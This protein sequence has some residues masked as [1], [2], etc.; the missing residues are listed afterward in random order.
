M[1]VTRTAAAPPESGQAVARYDIGP[2]LPEGALRLHLNEFR[3]PHAA[4]VLRAAAAAAAEPRALSEYT[5]GAPAALKAALAEY[6]DLPSAAYVAVG[7]GSD[8]LLRAVVDAAA[9]RGAAAVLG[10]VPTYTHFAHF[11]AL[12]GLAFAPVN[13]GL[14]PVPGDLGALLA[15]HE[16]ALRA[17]ALLYVCSPNNP[18]GTRWPTAELDA[19]AAAHP[20]SLLIVDEAYTE[21][22]GAAAHAE[23]AELAGAAALAA[24][25][26]RGA[27]RELNACSAVE[28][29][30]RRPNVVV[31]RTFSKVFGLA[32]LRI[33][34]I[35]AAPA[36]V[37]E[38]SAAL[39]PKSVTRIAA[40][41]AAAALANA[42]YYFRR[43][44]NAVA[45]RGYLARELQALGFDAREG[46]NFVL[47]G[48]G[49]P[50][51]VAA[52]RE[53]GVHI[54]DRGDLPGLQGY[55]RVTAGAP[56]DT[57]RT[58]TALRAIG[59]P[60][61]P[62]PAAFATPK[63]KVAALR[64][65][66]AAVAEVLNAAG[67]AWWVGGGTLLGAERCRPPGIVPWDN[68]FDVEYLHGPP[69]PAD[70]EAA[71][72]GAPADPVAPLG[73]A[74]AAWGLTLQRNRTDA[75]WQV[76]SQAPGEPLSDPFVDLSP[77]VWDAAS[78]YYHN[79]DARFRVE[80]PASHNAD[81]NARY[82]QGE[83]FPL[84]W[85]AFYDRLVPVPVASGAV[86]DRALG[87]TWR[88]EAVVRIGGRASDDPPARF[89]LAEFA[90]A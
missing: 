76:G 28:L 45:Q 6:L 86:L 73:P 27:R 35:A 62:L 11:A 46:G 3:Y 74:F 33:G 20:R 61:A 53:K 50:A 44:R 57:I 31:A 15:L 75:Y 70:A 47:V 48:V 40:A 7:A 21:F 41:A 18:T 34:Y 80:D 43:A 19:L 79:V 17:G 16:G 42:A 30:L 22:D 36:L 38:V 54:R 8:E 1:D 55:A 63:S 58:I 29:V 37:A 2:E 56:S 77:Y 39:T 24:L 81:C 64:R 78:G 32:G 60:A 13:V 72:D 84:R 5:T 9:L 68:D 23:L 88:R 52:L 4:E 87:P 82:R 12:R 25:S 59:P 26:P 66:G 90:P 89:E 69:A 85:A 10:V 51:A 65:L 49:G 83:L 14:A 67:A 71:G